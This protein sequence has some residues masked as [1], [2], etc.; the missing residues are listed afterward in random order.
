MTHDDTSFISNARKDRELRILGIYCV[1]SIIHG[2]NG[3]PFLA[4]PVFEY[5][6]TGAYNCISV[7]TNE[8]PDP[9]LHHVIEKVRLTIS[10]DRK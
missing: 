5:L 4:H 8:I 9:I 10:T 3:W 2:G 1:L 6:V 7:P